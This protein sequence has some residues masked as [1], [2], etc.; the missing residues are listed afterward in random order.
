MSLLITPPEVTVEIAP[1]SVW[2][3]PQGGKVGGFTEVMPRMFWDGSQFV[4][5]VPVE[6]EF[7]KDKITYYR[8]YPRGFYDMT[9]VIANQY[10]L[11]LVKPPAFRGYDAALVPEGRPIIFR[12]NPIYLYAVMPPIAPSL[13]V[14][15]L[16]FFL[17]DIDTKVQIYN[18]GGGELLIRYDTGRG[19]E[20]FFNE[21]IGFPVDKMD[22]F[23]FLFGLSY[24]VLYHKGGAV[25]TLT[26]QVNDK[27]GTKVVPI[28]SIG[29]IE[30]NITFEGYGAFNFLTPTYNTNPLT[31]YPQPSAP[32]AIAPL[33]HL[34]ITD[35]YG[36]LNYITQPFIPIR[37]NPSIPLIIRRYFIIA[38]PTM[39]S[40]GNW[41]QVQGVTSLRWSNTEGSLSGYDL[42]IPTSAAVR[43]TIGERQWFYKVRR[44]TRKTVP[45][46]SRTHMDVELYNPLFSNEHTFPRRFNP[47]LMRISDFLRVMRASV[48]LVFNFVTD[49]NTNAI[50]LKDEEQEFNSLQDYLDFLKELHESN[51]EWFIIGNTVYLQALQNAPPVLPAVPPELIASYQ[52]TISTEDPTVGVIG[53]RVLVGSQVSE[54]GV[55]IA[56]GKFPVKRRET[57]EI[58]GIYIVGE[59]EFV[60]LPSGEKAFVRKVDY[61][62][63][64]H[65]M[66]RTQLE[67][68]VLD[69]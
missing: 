16:Q 48:H 42:T 40:V 54:R 55:A 19:G 37:P 59:N 32:S 43:L 36:T 17:H 6:V 46:D 57:Y 50:I 61:S 26:V 65:D 3:V 66:P 30:G 12:G 63:T 7:G 64:P 35:A 2:G 51:A 67:L 21:P 58:L 68:E 52:Q 9:S 1:S 60:Q 23:T 44:V 10:G 14:N 18:Y 22:A 25:L 56:S 27:I 15:H 13:R 11:R 33:S 45:D 69:L 5:F 29:G 62:V 38:E 31:L 20:W 34:I 28:D 4:Y 39:T 41:Q 49:I 47:Y 53:N 8:Q 24:D